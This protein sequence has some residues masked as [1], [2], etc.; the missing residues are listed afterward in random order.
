M[1]H[2]IST[3]TVIFVGKISGLKH[4]SYNYPSLL[5]AIEHAPSSSNGSVSQTRLST[6]NPKSKKYSENREH[7]RD[8]YFCYPYEHGILFRMI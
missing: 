1:K 6:T 3:K 4:I 5:S 8:C 7:G 2:Q